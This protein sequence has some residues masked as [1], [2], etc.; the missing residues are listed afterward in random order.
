MSKMLVGIIPNPYLRTEEIY[1]EPKAEY[2]N[3]VL[4]NSRRKTIQHHQTEC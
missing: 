1:G 3:E 4:C 2:S